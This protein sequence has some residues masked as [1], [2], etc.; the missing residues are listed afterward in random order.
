MEPDD[1]DFTCYF[2]SRREGGKKTNKLR[3]IPYQ[4]AREDH[5]IREYPEVLSLVEALTPPEEEAR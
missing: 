4:L 3:F 2:Y 1:A 5:I